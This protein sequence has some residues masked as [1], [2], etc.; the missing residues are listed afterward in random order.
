MS[1]S[2][3]RKGLRSPK[4]ERTETTKWRVGQRQCGVE[5]AQWK[6]KSLFVWC[7]NHGDQKQPHVLRHCA[8]KP[9]HTASCRQTA[10]E[11]QRDDGRNKQQRERNKQSG[12]ARGANNRTC[13]APPSQVLVWLVIV[14][15]VSTREKMVDGKGCLQQQTSGAGVV[16]GRSV[17]CWHVCNSA[18]RVGSTE[19][20]GWLIGVWVVGEYICAG[21]TQQ[22][23]AL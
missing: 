11:T 22:Q 9:H 21:C 7:S 10:G 20:L 19:C 15:G 23:P 4:G 12:R 18:G 3:G 16:R 8:T 2:G 13:V 1:H 17:L 6:E 5:C 14:V